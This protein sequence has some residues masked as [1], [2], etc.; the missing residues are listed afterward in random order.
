MKYIKLY[1]PF[2]LSVSM[3]VLSYVLWGLGWPLI[4]LGCAIIGAVLGLGLGRLQEHLS[5]EKKE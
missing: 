5:D 3:V 4:N 2:A 1:W